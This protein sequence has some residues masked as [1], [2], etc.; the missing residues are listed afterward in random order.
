MPLAR[1]FEIKTRVAFFGWETALK[2]AA[3]HSGNA[4]N[5][6]NEVTLQR[7]RLVL[8]WDSPWYKAKPTRSTQPSTVCGMVK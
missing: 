8:G 6:I 2:M 7:A 4:W 3:W 5:Q 1:L